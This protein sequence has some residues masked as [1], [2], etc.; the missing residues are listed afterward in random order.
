MRISA[1]A[2]YAVRA[3]VE[4]AAAP[5]GP[6]KG[7]RIAHEQGI[8][9][10]FL[11]NILS[12]LNRSGIVNSQ[13]GADGGYWLARPANKITVAEVIRAVDGPLANV[14]GLRPEAVS[15]DGTAKGLQ[16]VWVA[17]RAN[18]RA[19]LEKVTLADIAAGA[20]PRAI[21]KLTV[22]EDAWQPH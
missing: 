6:M 16:E 15:Y 19:V 12:Q 9:I 18:L 5:P 1:K 3:A 13:R 20:L 10:K 11:E 17:V 21:T 14:R 22:D 8:P 4:L 2:D 7:D